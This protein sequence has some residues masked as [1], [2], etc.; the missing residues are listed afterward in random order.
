MSLDRA[1]QY[2]FVSH[3]NHTGSAE[4]DR[5]A[6]DIAL[7]S[8]QLW[9]L[10]A[11]PVKVHAQLS[12]WG[13]AG[14]DPA[15]L[16]QL[17]PALFFAF[18]FVLLRLLSTP[19]CER[20]G[21]FLR[22]VDPKTTDSG[23]SDRLRGGQ[24]RKL[25][26]FHAQLWLA[27]T[28]TVSTIFGYIVQRDKP[29]FG[30]PVNEENY[31]SFLSPHPYKVDI[32]MLLYYQYGLGF[33]MSELI[34][35]LMD[36][37]LK[38]SDFLL[39]LVHHFVTLFLMILSHCSYEH[40]VGA[41]VLFIHDA[42]DILL[43]VSKVINYVVEAAEK[44]KQKNKGNNNDTINNKNSNSN[45]KM[46]YNKKMITETKDVT[47]SSLYK[48]FFNSTT[49]NT[50]FAAFVVVFVFLRIICLPSLAF[51]SVGASIKIR[52]CTLSFWLLVFFFACSTAR[53]AVLLVCINC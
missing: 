51:A 25:R 5:L 34:F 38:R 22:V 26:K 43:A 52:M 3:Y 12:G 53:I 32:Y 10:A 1:R 16:P 24:R 31:V 41:Y 44:R 7:S 23:R 48:F 47:S 21:L 30:L 2:G 36:Y 19:Y 14:L 11:N 40:R 4:S 33:Y 6:N 42:S 50:C 20:L 13:G 17:L 18:V 28:Y 15:A 35:L 29:W 46:K 39:F 8:G 27:V 37:D 49:L 45:N 9:Q